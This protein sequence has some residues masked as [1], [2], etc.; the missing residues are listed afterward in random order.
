MISTY[1]RNP[2]IFAAF[3]APF[4]RWRTRRGLSSQAEDFGAIRVFRRGRGGGTSRP[5]G[6]PC[7]SRNGHLDPPKMRLRQENLVLKT[8]YFGESLEAKWWIKGTNKHGEKSQ[9]YSVLFHE[10]VDRSC[11]IGIWKQHN[12]AD[13]S[14]P[15]GDIDQHITN[16]EAI[17]DFF[18]SKV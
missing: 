12:L 4:K 13:F 11:K 1:H 17:G 6:I 2:G 16:E 3:R 18:C 14:T 8:K 15:N 5:L 7:A 10:C 9:R